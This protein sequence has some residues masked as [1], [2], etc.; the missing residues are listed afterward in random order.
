MEI[1]R[2]LQKLLGLLGAFVKS[3]KRSPMLTARQTLQLQL[4]VSETLTRHTTRDG[5]G[6]ALAEVINRIVPFQYFLHSIWSPEATTNYRISSYKT[7]E[8]KFKVYDDRELNLVAMNNREAMVQSGIFLMKPE[9]ARIYNSGDLL[10]LA[11]RFPSFAVGYHHHN[12]RSIMVFNMYHENGFNHVIIIS[13]VHEQ[14]FREEQFQIVASLLPQIKLGFDNLFKYEELRKQEEERNVQLMIMSAFT[15]YD[16]T[17]DL[18]EIALEAIRKLD[19]FIPFD[20]WLGFVKDAP[21]KELNFRIACKKSDRFHLL[22]GPEVFNKINHSPISPLVFREQH[23][24]LFEKTLLFVGESL[25]ALLTENSYFRACHQYLQLNSLLTMPVRILGKQDTLYMLGSKRQYAFT[26]ADLQSMKRILPYLSMGG[27]QFYFLLQM[28]ALTK[29]LAM[30]KHYLEEEI[31]STYN[32]E[33]MIGTSD[34]IKEVFK[35]IAQVA[36]TDS[37]VLILG[38]TGTG[39]E[40]IARAIHNQSPRKDKVL[41]KVNCASLPAQLIESEL[42][43]HEKGSFTGA[44]EKRIGK[45]ELASGG[46]IFLDEIGEMPLELQA[47]LLRVLQERVIDRIGGKTSISLDVR[48]IAATNRDLEIEVAEGRFRSDLF[49]R[50]SVFPIMVPPL[51]DRREDIPLLIQHFLQ[52]FSRKLKKPYRR[53]RNEVIEELTWYEWPG[54][55]RELENI[56]EQTVIVGEDN[57]FKLRRTTL[58]KTVSANRDS[59]LT[60]RNDLGSTEQQIMDA[61]QICKGKITGPHGVASLLNMR[62]SQI[63]A[64]ERKWILTALQKTGG[65][66][67]GEEGAANL[68]GVKATTLEAR[69]KKL[70]IS[71]AEIFNK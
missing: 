30:E 15:G 20:F 9:N 4:E 71:K 19:E 68:I 63:E 70:M 64:Y 44:F 57:P 42:F 39:K 10:E 61:L 21:L 17:T 38:E 24:S 54:N 58:K 35:Q 41:V 60:M 33:E 40:L 36:S 2:E 31:K 55:I 1:F 46:T 3:G 16:G 43:G 37:T 29:R 25:D 11:A 28:Q 13:D 7:A 50:L 32:F 26:E 45:F 27:Q 56:I 48:I 67:R 69:L 8:G 59:L 34:G 66:I 49:Y 22:S 65:R 5:I 6:L 18:D 62:A 52:R 12:I 51:R 14:A 53:L 47:K 23:Q